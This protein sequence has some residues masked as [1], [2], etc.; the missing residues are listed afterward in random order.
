MGLISCNSDPVTPKKVNKDG[1]DMVGSFTDDSLPN[2]IIKYY[3][4]NTDTLVAMKAFN[5]GI[6]EGE[7]VN[8]F[9]DK[10][11]Q[12]V[13]YRMGL[14]YGFNK[15]YDSTSGYLRQRNFSYFGRKVGPSYGYEPNGHLNFY[16]FYSL[17]NELLFTV[18]L[19]PQ[20]NKYQSDDA[21]A[22][23]FVKLSEAYVNNNRKIHA[24]FYLI[25]PPLS[26]V[27]YKICYMDKKDLVTDS[28]IISHKDDE[29]FWDNYIDVPKAGLKVALV[30]SRFDSTTSKTR[31]IINYLEKFK[32]E[33]RD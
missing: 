12:T 14:E 23:C 1:Y 2:G 10:V 8:Y 22:L 13:R 27:E 29:I 9:R 31:T 6:A 20:T 28:I 19:D 33:V 17:E 3:L 24:F 32:Q 7:S 25:F 16:D 15:I 30:V 4:P 21:E 5:N 18:E 26:R 11:I